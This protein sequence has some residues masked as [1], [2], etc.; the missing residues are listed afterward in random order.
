MHAHTMR[1]LRSAVTHVY[2]R[3]VDHSPC[4]AT[5]PSPRRQDPYYQHIL[6][7]FLHS[8][9]Y[10]ATY[11]RS[12]TVESALLCVF[13]RSRSSRQVP[14]DTVTRLQAQAFAK[15][16]VI[17]I[18]HITL[19][20]FWLTICRPSLHSS[21]QYHRAPPPSSSSQQH[22]SLPGSSLST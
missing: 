15:S 2:F 8:E 1:T 19:A 6:C 12:C 22:P 3:C 7:Y 4:C 11:E 5:G 13:R 9:M 16:H 20:V 17:Y 18:F 10:S 14:T 21:P